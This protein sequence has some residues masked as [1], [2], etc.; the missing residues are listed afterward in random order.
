MNRWTRVAAAFVLSLVACGVAQH[1]MIVVGVGRD[2][3]PL[4]AFFEIFPP[5]AVA[6]LLVTTLYVLVIQC[7]P[8]AGRLA[9]VLLPLM[10]AAG[11]C[12]LHRRRQ[13]PV[14]GHR[15]QYRL[16]SRHDGRVLLPRAMRACRPDPLAD[17]AQGS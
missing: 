12:A 4:K 13:Q 6:V 2:G 7:G 14:A 9:L 15:R 3:Y 17:A 5:L 8:Y 11:I 10:A 1:A 16:R